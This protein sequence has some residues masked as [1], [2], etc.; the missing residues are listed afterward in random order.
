ML[1]RNTFRS[2]DRWLTAEYVFALF[3]SY[4]EEDFQSS[5]CAFS[6]VF[7][8]NDPPVF[9]IRSR[10]LLTSAVIAQVQ[11]LIKAAGTYD[12]LSFAFCDELL[13]SDGGCRIDSDSCVSWQ[14]KAFAAPLVPSDPGQSSFGTGDLVERIAGIRRS[15]R[16]ADLPSVFLW[17]EVVGRI[18]CLFDN[19]G[20]TDSAYL[21]L[22]HLDDMRAVV[23][24]IQHDAGVSRALLAEL[25]K[26]LWGL[27]PW[28][29]LLTTNKPEPK[30]IEAID[31]ERI[32]DPFRNN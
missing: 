30:L 5:A 6:N 22:P 24:A 16:A 1:G 3:G 17:E 31:A 15:P 11:L 32:L 29:I 28:E 25:E 18:R 12:Y 20:V 2:T 9:Y 7:H 23:V 26:A 4:R 14:E 13:E 27:N 10:S 21:I 8:V 19:R